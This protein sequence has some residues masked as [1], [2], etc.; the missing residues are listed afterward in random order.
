MK[1]IEGH[2]QAKKR[3]EKVSCPA[4]LPLKEL[5]RVFGKFANIFAQEAQNSPPP[6]RTN[7]EARVQNSTLLT[8]I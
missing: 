3:G 7:V 8:F 4:P 6:N 5:G 1:M 2:L